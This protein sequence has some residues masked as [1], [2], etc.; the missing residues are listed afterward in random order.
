MFYKHTIYQF[1]VRYEKWYQ[2]CISE[3]RVWKDS[4]THTQTGALMHNNVVFQQKKFNN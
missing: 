2:G 3:H 1:K 4:L